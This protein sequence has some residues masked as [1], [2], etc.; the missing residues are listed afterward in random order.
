MIL[1]VKI[2]SIA[3]S[4]PRVG[5]RGR[6]DVGNLRKHSGCSPPPSRRR[7][8]TFR[9]RPPF[10]PN[11]IPQFPC[12]TRSRTFRREDGPGMHRS[13]IPA[14]ADTAGRLEY[15]VVEDTTKETVK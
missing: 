3:L 12:H 10:P 11:S 9:L 7:I 5:A 13:F 6:E 8:R 15:D 14:V 2:R 1:A 4:L